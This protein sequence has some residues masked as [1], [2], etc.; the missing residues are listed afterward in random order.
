M[1]GSF[2]SNQKIVWWLKQYQTWMLYFKFGNFYLGLRACV[3]VCEE[4]VN[5]WGSRHARSGWRLGMMPIPFSLT[6]ENAWTCKRCVKDQWCTNKARLLRHQLLTLQQT[7]SWALTLGQHPV[8]Q[9]YSIT[10][11]KTPVDSC[12]Y[13]FPW[14][15]IYL[16]LVTYTN[17]FVHFFKHPSLFF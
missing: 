14:L 13:I 3:C 15:L 12:K 7:T 8:S 17:W 16:I 9:L 10:E 4:G 1:Q 6:R 5:V 11:Q 2:N